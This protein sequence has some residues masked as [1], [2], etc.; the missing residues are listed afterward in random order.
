VVV[1]DN[2]PVILPVIVPVKEMLL[3][4]MLPLMVTLL[5]TVIL[6][7]KDALLFAKRLIFLSDADGF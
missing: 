5:A 4:E 6:F 1:P 3:T 2:A 7:A